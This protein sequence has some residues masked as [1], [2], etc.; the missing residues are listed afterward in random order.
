MWSNKEPVCKFC[1]R[2]SDLITP[3]GCVHNNGYVHNKCLV[4]SL[5]PRTDSDQD[6]IRCTACNMNMKYDVKRFVKNPKSKI[7][8]SIIISTIL[9]L[10]ATLIIGMVYVV[11]QSVLLTIINLI[12]PSPLA[13]IWREKQVFMHAMTNISD[14]TA[15]VFSISPQDQ[16][17]PIKIDACE[18]AANY[19]HMNPVQILDFGRSIISPIMD[20]VIKCIIYGL[21]VIN[22][23]LNRNPISLLVFFIAA[24]ITGS[25]MSIQEFNLFYHLKYHNIWLR[26]LY[27]LVMTVPHTFEFPFVV[28]AMM[29]FFFPYAFFVIARGN[30]IDNL[31]RL[32]SPNVKNMLKVEVQFRNFNKTEP[33]LQYFLRNLKSDDVAHQFDDITICTLDY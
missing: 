25:V 8:I 26:A 30:I 21:L 23:A 20:A 18:V 16:C 12:Y 9:L 4:N 31:R 19:V 17:I 33:S 7:A 10:F 6:E 28:Y 1:G 22:S 32:Y 3:C 27:T 15:M 11:I 2:D 24:Y 29:E 13:Y 5:K 14:T